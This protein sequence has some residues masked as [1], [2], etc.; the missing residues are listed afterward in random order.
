MDGGYGSNHSM[1]GLAMTSFDGQKAMKTPTIIIERGG[2]FD[3]I[4]VKA[5]E[6]IAAGDTVVFGEGI[7]PDD[8]AVQFR[9]QARFTRAM[10]QDQAIPCLPSA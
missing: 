1:A 2:G 7:L 6:W 3:H 9:E 10:A 8:I 4:R 5:S